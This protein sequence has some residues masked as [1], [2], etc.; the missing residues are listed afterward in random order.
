MLLHKACSH[1]VPLSLTQEETVV[2]SKNHSFAALRCSWDVKLRHNTTT[3]FVWTG[4]HARYFEWNGFAVSHNETLGPSCCLTQLCNWPTTGPRGKK[5]SHHWLSPVKEAGSFPL[6]LSRLAK[7]L[8]LLLR[9]GK[10][11]R[12]TLIPT[13][14]KQLS[15]KHGRW[16]VTVFG[17]FAVWRNPL[18]E[19]FERDKKSAIPSASLKKS[20]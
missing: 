20:V 13:K 14:R 17:R 1:R 9:A 12:A 10:K 8:A 19:A 11:E 15:C 7:K 3:L 4:R 2:V 6:R 18:N 5:G 16:K